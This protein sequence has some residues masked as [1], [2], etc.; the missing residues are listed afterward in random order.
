MLQRLI[1]T[2]Y[3]LIDHL[4]I[5]FKSGLTIVTGETGAGKSII[6]GALALILGGRADT[7]A[8][9]D[10]DKKTVV[11]AVVNVSHFDLGDF[12]RDN[13]LD[14]AGDEL[15]VRREISPSGR[16]R[17]L[18]NDSVVPL[19]ALRDLMTRLVDIH[20][21]HSNTM[22]ARP[23]FQLSV[24][25]ALAAHSALLTD[26]RACYDEYRQA[27]HALKKAQTLAEQNRSQEDY[28]RFQLTQLDEA[29]IVPHEDEELE[30]AQK[31]LANAASIR[32]TLWDVSHMLDDEEDS[33]LQR[34]SRAAQ[35]LDQLEGT[36]SDINGM[37][38]RVRT[39]FIDLQDIAQSIE[40]IS[41]NIN[42]DPQELAR[43]DDRLNTI[44]SLVRK[45]NVSGVDE[46]LTLQEQLRE[47][48]SLIDNSEEH[49]ARLTERLNAL[50][51]QVL[52]KAEAISS[53]RRQ[54]A[55]L[56][57]D[58]VKPLARDLGMKNIEFA[59]DFN[60]VEPTT[61][62]CDA[63]EFKFAFNKNQPLMPVK[64]TASGGEISRLMLCIKN[65]IA[66]SIE[67]P[68]LIFDEVDT[69]VSGEVA[70]KIGNLMRDMSRHLQV[71]AITHLP[72]VAAHAHAHLQVSKTDTDQ[73]TLTSL[74][75][76]DD[77]QHV[78]EIARMLSGDKVGQAAIENARQLIADSTL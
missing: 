36:L 59:I 76:L 10:K 26:Y 61:T 57:I 58:R 8:M 60:T 3:A 52:T 44:Y 65:I 73:A 77:E 54:A 27:A 53:S 18:V 51:E 5:D 70:G 72:Q 23:D 17:A 32:E 37:G 63:I 64:D 19:A 39:A 30:A 1:I 7:A 50:R 2:N 12:M 45:H 38:E 16:S 47:Q 78:L 21:Q 25:D 20:S 48:L 13:E 6:L 42:D 40:V 9:R 24:L 67:L 28:L 31:V 15:I 66:R 33:T 14:E 11:E 71:I 35:K 75:E 29:A 41:G 22:L 69:G 34:L 46:L 55:T 56:F 4:E 68:T 74:R 62:G 43:V 49:I